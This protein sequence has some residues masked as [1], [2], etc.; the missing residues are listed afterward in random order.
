MF[1]GSNGSKSTLFHPIHGKS[2]QRVVDPNYF[3]HNQFNINIQLNCERTSLYYFFSIGR[4]GGIPIRFVL[5]PSLMHLFV[6]Q[7]FS[8][9]ISFLIS[10]FHSWPVMWRPK[11]VHEWLGSWAWSIGRLLTWEN[12]SCAEPH[13]S[14]APWFPFNKLLEILVFYSVCVFFSL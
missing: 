13:S 7:I 12:L 4:L 2:I 1:N 5:K 6:L 14:F 11:P 3:Q 10:L 8:K 9:H